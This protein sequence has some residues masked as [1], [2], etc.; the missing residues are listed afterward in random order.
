MTTTTDNLLHKQLDTATERTTDQG[1]FTAIAAAYTPDRAGE[2][3]RRGSF[4]T[5]IGRWLASGKQLPVHHEHKGSAENV[6]GSIDP[7]TMSE[8]D[9][10]LYVEGKIDIADSK[11]AREVWRSMKRNRA[12]LS[13]GYLVLDKATRADGLVELREIDLL[14]VSIVSQ[15]ANADTV[16]L[17]TK[18]AEGSDAEGSDAEDAGDHATVM[19]FSKHGHYERFKA[20]EQAQLEAKR[21]AAIAERESKPIEIVSFEVSR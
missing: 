16:V 14:E 3:I 12:S 21:L 13:I 5:T 9:A 7:R 4:T 1:D 6:V 11:I 19:A 2:V 10:G 15:P 8:T 20:T 18:H 17:S